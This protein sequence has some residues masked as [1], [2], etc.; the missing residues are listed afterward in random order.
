[1]LYFE[2]KK[3]SEEK[4]LLEKIFIKNKKIMALEEI[5]SF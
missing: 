5:F 1:M 3:A 4:C 2:E